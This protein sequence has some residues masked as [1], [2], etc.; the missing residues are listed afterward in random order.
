MA[1]G[2]ILFVAGI[3]FYFGGKGGLGRLPGDIA[4]K[5][6]GFSFYF[7][8]ESSIVI[9]IIVSLAIYLYYKLRS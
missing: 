5:K 8:L 9:S 1:A 2:A 7:P 4:V 3:I 6:P